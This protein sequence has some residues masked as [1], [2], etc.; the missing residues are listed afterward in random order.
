[1]IR[2][3]NINNIVRKQIIK[4]DIKKKD[5]LNR[6]FKNNGIMLEV[7]LNHK[8]LNNFLYYSI[9]IIY[10][11]PSFICIIGVNKHNI[12]TFFFRLTL[13]HLYVVENVF[14]F[15]I[16]KKYRKNDLLFYKKYTFT[17]KPNTLILSINCLIKI[18]QSIETCDFSEN[19]LSLLIYTQNVNNFNYFKFFVE[20][21]NHFLIKS[22]I[23]KIKLYFCF[24]KLKFIFY[25]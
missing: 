4:F 3:L 14:L 19:I 25:N 11:E 1:M 16:N 6:I 2:L 21:K 5:N 24:Q 17:L 15:F 12:F 10:D 23:N 13:S 7:F 20:N 8:I 18:T 9:N 22:F